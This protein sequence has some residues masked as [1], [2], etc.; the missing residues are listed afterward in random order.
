MTRYDIAAKTLG[1][2]TL[3][4]LGLDCHKTGARF[5]DELPANRAGNAYPD[6]YANSLRG[7]SS[8][9]GSQ[10]QRL[11]AE[12]RLKTRLPNNFYTVQGYFYGIFK[13]LK[14]SVIPL[15]LAAGALLIP[16]ADKT[17]TSIGRAACAVGLA[18]YGLN[19]FFFDVM[20]FGRKKYFDK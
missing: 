14:E 5:S 13:Q 18:L 17:K 11:Y 7:G 12:K 20:Q 16:H 8:F 1:I 15:G 2:V 10:V 4:A 3:G 19:Y 9:V 6:I